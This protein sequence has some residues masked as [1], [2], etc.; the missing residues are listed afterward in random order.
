MKRSGYAV[1]MMMWVGLLSSACASAPEA[2]VDVDAPGLEPMAYGLP[3]TNGIPKAAWHKWKGT[4][5]KAL[6]TPLMDGD[7]MNPKVAGAGDPEQGGDERLLR[8]LLECTVGGEASEGE[9]SEG[10]VSGAS[11]WRQGG[12]EEQVINNVLECVIAFVNDKMDG[13]DILISGAQL[14]G[15]EHPDFMHREAV[16]CAN[17]RGGAVYVDVYTTASLERGCGIDAEAALAQRYCTEGEEAFAECG[18][19]YRGLLERS[20]CREVEPSEYGH[21]GGQYECGGRLCTMTWLTDITPDWCQPPPPP[22]T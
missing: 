5:A 22:P 7:V 6:K 13:V 3:G 15:E 11:A 1:G 14:D 4:I 19:D 16:W 10:M 20:R 17:A 12:L 2:E 8:H 21:Q 9:A 18:L